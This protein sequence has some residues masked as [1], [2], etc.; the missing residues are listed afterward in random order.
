MDRH[1]CSNQFNLIMDTLDTEM[2]LRLLVGQPKESQLNSPLL[3]SLTLH[4][5][6]HELFWLIVRSFPKTEKLLLLHALTSK[7]FELKVFTASALHYIKT[8]MFNHINAATPSN[9]SAWL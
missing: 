7:K 6:H 2:K 8:I 4:P 3:E 5:P 1:I 9:R